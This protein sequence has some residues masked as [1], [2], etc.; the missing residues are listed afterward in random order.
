MTN[1]EVG[2]Y[3]KLLCHVWLEDGIPCDSTTLQAL[4]NHPS[5][6]V[7]PWKKIWLKVGKCFY[8]KDGKLHHKKL[9]YLREKQSEWREKSRKGGLKSAE[10]KRV[11]PPLKNGT[12]GG[13][14]MVEPNVNPSSSYAS[15]NK[16]NNISKDIYS[17][18][19]HEVI[20]HLNELTGKKFNP[21]S[22]D[23]IKCINGRL[24]DKNNPASKEDLIRV[25]D[26]KCLQWYRTEQEAYLR[27]STLFGPKNFENYRNER[28]FKPKQKGYQSTETH[29]GKSKITDPVSDKL[30]D[31]T[32]TW[33]LS[34][35]RKSGQDPDDCLAEFFRKKYMVF[36]IQENRKEWE[37]IQ[38][39]GPSELF[40]FVNIKHLKV[41]PKE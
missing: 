19:R 38:I 14:K 4:C 30:W 34:S 27:P 1:E 20:N 22:S 8:K 29:V 16:N 12:K 40:S 36:E 41:I 25:V 5:T 35:A 18:V 10:K 3:L 7:Q 33:I 9:D 11:K 39:K 32:A 17:E 21:D 13:S 26:I 24:K 37:S 2:V 31:Q 6:L 15:Y 23:T 28:Y